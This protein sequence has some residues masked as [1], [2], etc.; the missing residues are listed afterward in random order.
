VYLHEM[1]GGQYTNLKEQ[2]SKAWGINGQ[3]YRT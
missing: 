1:P 3:D 2:A